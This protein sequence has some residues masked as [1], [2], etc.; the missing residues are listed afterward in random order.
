MPLK[1]TL[2]PLSLYIDVLWP[3]DHQKRGICRSHLEI[4]AVCAHGSLCTSQRSEIRSD[5]KGRAKIRN[6]V[7]LLHT[8]ALF[9]TSA[10]VTITPVLSTWWFL[11]IYYSERGWRAVEATVEKRDVLYCQRKTS[12]QD[13][14][15]TMDEISSIVSESLHGTCLPEV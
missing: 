1:T 9:W 15:A 14:M 11:P 5:L 8:T 13:K 10:V 3:C 12:A 7:S 2:F 4:I 6:R